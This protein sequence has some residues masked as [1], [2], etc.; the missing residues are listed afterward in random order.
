MFF[1]GYGNILTNWYRVRQKALRTVIYSLLISLVNIGLS[2]LFVVIFKWG[3]SGVFSALMA[4]SILTGLV[5]L[6]QLR[7]WISFKYFDLALCKQMLKFGLPLI[8]AAIAI[9]LLNSSAT[10][11]LQFLNSQAEVGLFSVGLS[12]GSSMFLLT[13]AFQQAWAP[14][15]YSIV[16]TIQAKEVFA[17]VL[18]WYTII[19][20]VASM[21]LFFF[22]HEALVIFT[23]PLYYT[24]DWTACLIGLNFVLIGYGY[25]ASVGTG[26]AK[27]NKPY[28]LSVF[29]GSVITVVL[30][31]VLIPFLGKTGAALAMVLGQLCIPVIVFKYSQQ[32]YPIPYKF[33]YTAFFFTVAIAISAVGKY[34]LDLQGLHVRV[35]YKLTVALLLLAALYF[36]IIRPEI[37]RLTRTIQ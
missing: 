31:F 23:Q 18:L 6:V 15:A 30:F 8:P 33:G 25:I 3:L 29:I 16:N 26:I 4:G 37:K 20:S 13:G 19:V 22:S 1:T 32:Y 24:A 34:Y 12:L 17:S 27:R 5:S 35:Y 36:F 28:A 14:F 21:V 11:F 9:W 7:N 2:I 10:Y